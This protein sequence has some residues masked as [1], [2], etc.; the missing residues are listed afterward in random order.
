MVLLLFESPAGLALF[1]VLD[2]GKLKQAETE[3]RA[4][5]GLCRGMHGRGSPSP[6][7]LAGAHRPRPYLVPFTSRRRTSGRTLRRLMRPRRCALWGG[8]TR[9]QAPGG[10]AGR[11]AG[12][13]AGRLRAGGRGWGSRSGRCAGRGKGKGGR[14][15]PAGCRP[16]DRA[17]RW[18]RNK[19]Q[20]HRRV[21]AALLASAVRCCGRVCDSLSMRDVAPAL[22]RG[23]S[24]AAMA[25]APRGARGVWSSG[26]RVAASSACVGGVIFLVAP[27]APFALS[28][29]SLPYSSFVSI[30]PLLSSLVV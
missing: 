21:A 10:D 17:G 13:P 8:R 2:E 26:M 11:P 16:A 25:E 20:R 6:R 18:P 5:G 4:A 12:R 1:K 14:G 15:M 24:G 9:L 27:S 29:S 19:P 22:R 3:V 28:L 7:A 30:R 23:L